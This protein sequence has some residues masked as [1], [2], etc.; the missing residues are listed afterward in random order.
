[1]LL[2]SQDS[3]KNS[4]HSRKRCIVV[5]NHSA[6]QDRVFWLAFKSC[7]IFPKPISPRADWTKRCWKRECFP[8]TAETC[9]L[10]G[11]YR[12]SPPSDAH[13]TPCPQRESCAVGSPG[14]SPTPLILRHWRLSATRNTSLPPDLARHNCDAA[15]SK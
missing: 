14:A 12:I 10:L 4:W 9:S 2:S 7:P 6:K 5:L 11:H 13:C 3:V 1:M 8:P 15:S